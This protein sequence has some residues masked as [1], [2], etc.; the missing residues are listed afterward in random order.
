MKT[1]SRISVLALLVVA[2]T[3]VV[4]A[5][6]GNRTGTGGATELL[7]PVGA[8][9]LG[10]G[11][12]TVATTTGINALFWNPAGITRADQSVSV[13]FSHMSYI[14]DI[15]VEYGAVSTNFP[16][17]GTV[18]LSIKALSVGDIPIT[19]TTDPDGESQQTYSPQLFVAGLSYARQL[20]ERISVGIT[21]SLISEHLGEVSATGVA[22]SAGVMYQ[23]LAE[24]QGLSLGVA[25]KNIGPQMQFGGSGL[26]QFASVSTLNRTPG[27]LQLQAAPFQLPSSMEIGLGYKASID[28]HNVVQLTGAFQNNNYSE[29]VYSIGGEYSYDKT[30]FVRAG[31]SFAPTTPDNSD[32]IYGVTFGVGIQYPVGD[33]NLSVDYAYRSTKFFSGNNVITIMLGF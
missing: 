24:I 16:D 28:E 26:N 13:L 19:T 15:G 27:Y 6:S 33:T 29:D 2:A 21:T 20:S 5:D 8:K 25:V 22:F 9:D 31:D 10:M 4:F 1:L 23:H 3:G 17:F 18:A 14:A 7:I 11:G 12:S 32:Y 30:F